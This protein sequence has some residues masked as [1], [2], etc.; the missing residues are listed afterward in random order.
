MKRLL[1][2]ALVL[3]AAGVARS[4]LQV[5]GSGKQLALDPEQFPPEQRARYELFQTKCS[6]CHP[7]ARPIAALQ[8]GITPVS[9][10]PFDD[11]YVKKY[12]VKMMR[13]PN[14]G[15]AKEDAREI[16][17]FLRYALAL[18]RGTPLPDNPPAV[19]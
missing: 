1:A 11:G 17:F 13:K 7:L 3:F 4:E 18:H 8:T 6:K 15:I 12:V 19:P 2:V 14:S 9:G 16:I 5:T 10:S